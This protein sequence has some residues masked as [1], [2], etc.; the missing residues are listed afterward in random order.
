MDQRGG[1][2]APGAAPLRQGRRGGSRQ[3]P[4]QPGWPRPNTTPH[5]LQLPGP[6]GKRCAGSPEPHPVSRWKA[7]PDP[8]RSPLAS[9]PAAC[10][11]LTLRAARPPGG[12]ALA[13]ARTPDP[14]RAREPERRPRAR[15]RQ[16]RSP[17]GPAASTRDPQ[18]GTR[19]GQGPPPTGRASARLVW[20]GG[21]P[22]CTAE[23]P[24]RTSPPSYVRRLWPR[25]PAR[26]WGLLG[27]P[28]RTTVRPG[29]VA[30][31]QGSSRPRHCRDRPGAPPAAAL[32]PPAP[33]L[34][35]RAA[36]GKRPARPWGAYGRAPARAWQ[37]PPPRPARP[38][39][40]QGGGS[41]AHPRVW[42]RGAARGCPSS[43]AAESATVPGGR[44]P[45]A[46]LPPWRERV[47]GPPAFPARPSP[48]QARMHLWAEGG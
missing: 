46:A 30:G 31:A 4:W 44:L 14:G 32:P 27:A 48:A 33:C 42:T 38:A 28:P 9:A 7:A 3:C 17:A 24:P 36:H 39:A 37:S 47:P 15:G 2:L 8:S 5:R 10:R 45:A 43:R 35:G 6:G 11:C 41:P 12:S 34:A 40:E 1:A 22:I 21:A 29:W 18:C 16:C 13:P 20:T 25:A 26:S 19:C 23:Q